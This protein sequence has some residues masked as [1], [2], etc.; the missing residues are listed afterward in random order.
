MTFDDLL[1]FAADLSFALVLG[2][3][4]IHGNRPFWPS[5]SRH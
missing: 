3:A 5:W 1:S 2:W 4:I